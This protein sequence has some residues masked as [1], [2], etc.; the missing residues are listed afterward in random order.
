VPTLGDDD[1]LFMVYLLSQEKDET[2]NPFKVG[3]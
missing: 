2:N 3:R 1:E